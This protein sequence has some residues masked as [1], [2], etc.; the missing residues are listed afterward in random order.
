MTENREDP[1]PGL[2]RALRLVRE[3][4]RSF[5]GPEGAS[6]IRAAADAIEI[7]IDSLSLRGESRRRAAGSPGPGRRAG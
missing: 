3:Q 5:P 7:E 4:G 1:L 2:R 6:A